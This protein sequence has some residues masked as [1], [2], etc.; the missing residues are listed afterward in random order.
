MNPMRRTVWLLA[1]CQALMNSG[2]SLLAATS[3]L[4]GFQ[5]AADKSLATLPLAL[6]LFTGMLT[7]V[8]ASFLMARTG[9]RAGFIAGT[10]LGL[11]GAA[12]A[13]WG[14]VHGSF[15]HFCLASALIGGFNGFGTYY[16]FA[17]ADA[18]T[19]DYRSRA[20]SFVMA[21]GV[22]AAVIGPN[23]AH[24]TSGWLAA[25]EF[26]GSYLSLL[27]VYGLSL[28]ILL[29]LRIPPRPAAARVP[30][31]PLAQIARQ[32]AFVVALA[33]GALSYA[34]MTLV[35]TATPLAMH[36]HAHAF[37]E[38]A[39]VI[40]WHM[41]GMF[42]PAFAAG[43]LIRRFGVLNVMLAGALLYFGCIAAGLA[44]ATVAHFW[45]A[46]TLLGVG[47]S[48]LFVGATTLLTETYA[49][50]EKA[51]AQALNDFVVFSVITA[52]SLSAGMLQHH[53]GWQAV[54]LALLPLTVAIIAAL[55]WL[56]AGRRAAPAALARD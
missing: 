56:R 46:L 7:T 47:W 30:G 49:E 45:V 6:T 14:I 19:A 12:L 38:T 11:G 26:A 27:G 23:L 22:V 31:R 4:V 17:A 15:L 54:N 1:G 8:P 20:I 33:C 41:L 40:E 3:A 5:L 34:G 10:A 16:R 44:G 53:L 48:F 13:A 2:N 36:R 9:R 18:A 51:K 32:P 52:S 29:F 55:L 37:A 43:H 21:G 28:A 39:F 35:M 25:H 42:L 50:S 24:W